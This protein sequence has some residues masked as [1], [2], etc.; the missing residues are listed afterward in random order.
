MSFLLR[1]IIALVLIALLEFYFIKKVHRSVKEYFPDYP[2]K[3]LSRITTGIL[4]FFNLYPLFLT[5]TWIYTAIFNAGRV[6]IPNNF[7]FDYL[8]TYPFW[9]GIIIIVQS[10]LFFLLLDILKGIA[11]VFIRGYKDKIRSIELKIFPFI[12][13]GFISYVP[14]RIIYDYH[15]VDVNYVKFT[16]E[17]MPAE[18]KDFRLVFISDIQADRY[19][20]R[21]RL[22]RFVNL[23]NEQ[24][25]DL[26]LIAGDFITYTPDY[27]NL[28]VDYSG[29]MKAAH[30]VYSCVGDHDNWA[31]PADNAKSINEITAALEGKGI[32]MIDNG[33]QI[34]DVDGRQI[35]ITFVTNTYVERI[36]TQLLD[37]LTKNN[38][39]TDIKIFL[40]HQ[41]RAFLIDQAVKRN[42][43]MYLAGHTHGGQVTFLFPFINLTPTL[44]ETD[45][46]KGE[47]HI[48]GMMMYITRGL[49]MSLVPIRY[50]STP[51]ITVIEF[52]G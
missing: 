36:D 22:S 26:I 40:T 43:D 12:I 45:Y 3:K 48:D 11:L 44:I 31:Y 52:S 25:A 5:G 8:L 49:G 19:T 6:Q 13:V 20:N 50:N 10:S 41:P 18:L 14:A 51:E 39:K 47:F 30:G 4:I 15:A 46:V 1:I 7:V 29:R 32:K 16:K 34:I 2:D 38:A 23:V 35:G 17:N 42:Y 28:S 9:V 21:Y 27:I 33:E 37:K 24:N